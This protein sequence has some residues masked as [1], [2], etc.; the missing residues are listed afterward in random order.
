[1]NGA[2]IVMPSPTEVVSV[3]FKGLQN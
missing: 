1:V 2:D 3:T